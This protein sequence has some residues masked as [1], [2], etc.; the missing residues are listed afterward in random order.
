ML[1]DYNDLPIAVARPSIRK[2]QQDLLCNFIVFGALTVLGCA[3]EPIAGWMDNVMGVT[4]MMIGVGVGI[5]RTVM[6]YENLITDIVP[7]DYAVNLI[8]AAAWDVGNRAS[9]TIRIFNCVSGP[10]SSITWSKFC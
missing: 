5:V 6:V 1:L 9:K 3:K 10:H 2:L 4:G 7:V 8:I